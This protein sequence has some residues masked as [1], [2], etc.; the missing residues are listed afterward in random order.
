M[1]LG[2][3]VVNPKVVARV[4]HGLYLRAM[5]VP[6]TLLDIENKVFCAIFCAVS[7]Y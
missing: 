1:K 3:W 4:D 2:I 5:P 7:Y 6:F